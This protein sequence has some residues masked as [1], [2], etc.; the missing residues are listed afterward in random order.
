VSEVVLLFTSIVDVGQF[1]SIQTPILKVRKR[2][3][4]RK[5]VETKDICT[6]ILPC[7][8]EFCQRKL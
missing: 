3:R 7:I 1:N 2:E 6:Q 5:T 4:M 8:I